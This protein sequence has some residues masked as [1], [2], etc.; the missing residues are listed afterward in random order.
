M[1]NG[2]A[3]R[4]PSCGRR[5]AR[6]AGTY[7]GRKLAR[8]GVVIVTVN[9]RLGVLGYLAHP[10]LSK[11]S[12]IGSSGNY[13]L[14][15]QIAA[16]RWVR[17]NIVRFGGD[18]AN[19]TVA[20]QSAGGG[21]AMLVTVSPS[22][23]G[24]FQKAVFESGAALGLPG[25]GA[26][27]GLDEAE[28]AGASF[29]RRLAATT[30]DQLRALQAKALITSSVPRAATGP[31]NI[32]TAYRSGRDAGVP[33]LQGWNSNEAAR[34][35]DHV[36]LDAYAATVRQSYGVIAPD[37]LRLYPATTDATA[38]GAAQS[39]ISDAGFSLRSWSIAEARTAKKPAAA[40]LYQFDGSL[41]GPD[42]SRA[43]G[44]VH[45][46]E[47]GYVWGKS[48][49]QR[50]WSPTDNALVETVHRYWLNFMRTGDPNGRSLPRW[51]HY[52][53]AATA[54]SLRAGRVTNELPLRVAK[55]KSINNVLSNILPPR[56][57]L[58]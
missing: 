12:P 11:E 25:T 31:I 29:A 34:F 1:P 5:L 44:A 58:E 37:M 32:T 7:D 18:P 43:K 9:Y 4:G 45:S 15:D 17:G 52:G 57:R 50:H 33:I 28:I 21:S 24:L 6:R 20:G 13:G 48:D 47:L 3:G 51:A 23:R 46:D 14:L 41:P 39:L 35:I 8:R 16:L 55:L 26:Q 27:I 49:P 22:A 19:V 56:K 54:L 40:F 2:W 38:T 30:A 53:R 36:T 42:G 10:V